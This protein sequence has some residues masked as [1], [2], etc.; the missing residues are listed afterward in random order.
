MIESFYENI[1]CPQCGSGLDTSSSQSWVCTSCDLKIPIQ[2]GKPIFTPVPED[3]IP[4]EKLVRS[5]DS[6]SRWRQSNWNFLEREVRSLHPQSR[7]L[8]IGSGRGDFSSLFSGHQFL[9]LDIYP[10]P[11][12]DLVCDLNRC[13]PFRKNSFDMIALLNVIEHIHD[14]K[15]LLKTVFQ[16]LSPGGK[17]VIT[18]PF[19]LKIHQA[20]VDYVR[21]THFALQKMA[22]EMG[23]EIVGMDAFED[24]AGMINEASRYYQFWELSNLN[25][26]QYIIARLFLMDIKTNTFFLELI[27]GRGRLKDAKSMKYPAPTGYQVVFKKPLHELGL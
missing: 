9:E 4:S 21:F 23:F 11:E 1:I 7:I 8:D 27:S 20:P 3:L 14:P 15:S 16:L 17:A 13:V 5:A 6:G 2:Q 12:V 26:F 25:L 24:P 22:E 18:I 19:M 10:Y